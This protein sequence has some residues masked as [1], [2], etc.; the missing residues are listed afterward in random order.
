MVGIEWFVR[1][2]PPDAAHCKADWKLLL[3]ED[4][5]RVEP[6]LEIVRG[7]VTGSYPDDEKGGPRYEVWLHGDIW[8]GIPYDGGEESEDAPWLRLTVEDVQL[9]RMSEERL[10]ALALRS[11]EGRIQ[12]GCDAVRDGDAVRVSPDYKMI[13]IGMREVDLSRKPKARAFLRF[14]RERS[15]KGEFHVEEMRE[16]FNAQFGDEMDGKGWNSDRLREDLF[17]GLGKED[18]DLLFDTVN[19][20]AGIYRLRI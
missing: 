18:F 4:Y 6:F 5:G 9:W 20:G 10:A 13:R 2:S 8:L 7:R 15:G 14:V 11:A 12:H 1:W 19:L 3:G 17:R 16:A